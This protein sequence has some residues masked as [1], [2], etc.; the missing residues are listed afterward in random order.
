MA[1]SATK[2]KM[3]AH[4][5][6]SNNHVTKRDQKLRPP[7]RFKTHNI[8]AA[9]TAR[10]NTGD[11]HLQQTGSNSSKTRNNTTVP[12]ELAASQHHNKHPYS[13]YGPAQNKARG[14]KN[15]APLADQYNCYFY[16]LMVSMQKPL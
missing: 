6:S 16:F 11:H 4:L 1:P 2:S 7:N 10:S 5:A 3:R 12:A 8:Q 9:A 15:L 13:S 14:Y